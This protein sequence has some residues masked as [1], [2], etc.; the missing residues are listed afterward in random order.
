MGLIPEKIFLA[1]VSYQVF[2]QNQNM[3]KGCSELP[4]KK[5]KKTAFY[6][7]DTFH[8]GKKAFICQ[9]FSPNPCATEQGI[10]NSASGSG[11][12]S[13]DQKCKLVV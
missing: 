6:K 1:V 4:L 3:L 10:E 5:K 11:Q 2:S 13:T 7:M 12:A 8:F 9:Y